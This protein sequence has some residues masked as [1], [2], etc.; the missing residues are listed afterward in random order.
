M[1]QLLL[2]FLTT[3]CIFCNCCCHGFVQQQQQQHV[4]SSSSTTTILRVIPSEIAVD[5]AADVARTQFFLWFFGSSGGLG[6]ALSA[7]PRMYS[8]TR[9]IQSLK[10]SP[11]LGGVNLGLSPLCGYPEDL[12]S[13]DV[14]K[15]INNK[16]TVSQLVEK[17][18][19]EG[20][21]LSS[22]GYVTFQAFEQANSGANPLAIRL[23]ATV[24]L[25]SAKDGWFPSWSL[26]NGILNIP[27][28]W[29]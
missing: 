16:L 23:A 11:S 13:K 7:F 24:A 8:K 29:I 1:M 20:N 2:V 10:G 4:V 14:E 9:Y 21:F 3:F 28:Y 19:I 22:K 27:N 25:T 18:P 17:F 15:I 5:A 6:V 26:E 12:A